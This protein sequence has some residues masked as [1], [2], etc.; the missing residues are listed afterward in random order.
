MRVSEL[1]PHAS[2]RFPVSSPSRSVHQGVSSCASEVA[3]RWLKLQCAA[4]RR[5][6]VSR[7]G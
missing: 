5:S 1:W 3:R 6:T 7:R 4:P 2:H